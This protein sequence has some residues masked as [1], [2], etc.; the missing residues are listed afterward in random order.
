[1]TGGPG[2]AVSATKVDDT[3]A[4]P[5]QEKGIRVLIQSS[6]Y[7]DETLRPEEDKGLSK[8]TQQVSGRQR[9]QVL[10]FGSV[11]INQNIIPEYS[12]LAKEKMPNPAF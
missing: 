1:M 5:N 7:P 3:V 4:I 10:P 8:V 2:E 9:T 11:P 6:P 12:N